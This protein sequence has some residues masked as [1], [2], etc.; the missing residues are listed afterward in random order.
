MNIDTTDDHAATIGALA[1]AQSLLAG[2]AAT[3]ITRTTQPHRGT[4]LG[5]GG[6]RGTNSAHTR[7][8]GTGG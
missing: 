1:D 5:V 6:R 8:L 3:T 2:T 4:H 7:G